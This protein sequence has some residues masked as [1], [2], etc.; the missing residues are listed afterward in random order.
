MQYGIY[1]TSDQMQQADTIGNRMGIITPAIKYIQCFLPY[2][3][4]AE[5]SRSDGGGQRVLM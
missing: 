1:F 3:P 2:P 5:V 4:L